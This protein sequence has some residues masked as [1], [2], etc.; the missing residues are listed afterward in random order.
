MGAAL[1]KPWTSEYYVDNLIGST[2]RDKLEAT[3]NVY[4]QLGIEQTKGEQEKVEKTLAEGVNTT[5][6]E[7]NK[8]LVEF[9]LINKTAAIRAVHLITTKG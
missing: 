3:Q 4:N 5:I 9:G 8:M 7:M 6:T 2:A 1:I